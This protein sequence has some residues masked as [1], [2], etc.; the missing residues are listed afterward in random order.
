[1]SYASRL[2]AARGVDPRIVVDDMRFLTVEK[3]G[4]KQSLTPEG[5][6]LIQDTTVARAGWQIYAP[7]EIPGAERFAPPPDGVFR[8]WRDE[9]E[10]FAPE[11]VASANGKPVVDDHPDDVITPDTH[12]GAPGVAL[13]PRRGTGAEDD[14]LIMDLMIYSRDLI[15]AIGDGKR[16]LSLGYDVDYEELEPGKLAQK[17]IRINH[18]ALVDSGR[19]GPRCAIGDHARQEEPHMAKRRN[20]ASAF[21]K[22]RAYL[23]KN[24]AIPAADK[25]ELEKALKEGEAEAGDAEVEPGD[26]PHHLEIHNHMPAAASET[27]DDPID[28]PGSGDLEARVAR[29][30]TAIHELAE[31][32]EAGGVAPTDD[33]PAP[34]EER[35][36]KIEDAVSKMNGEEEITDEEGKAILGQLEL[37][38]P[39]GAE[40]VDVR[41]AKDSRYLADSFRA[42]VALAEIVAPGIRVPA[43]DQKSDP[44]RCF[45]SICDLRR[46]A[47]DLAYSKPDTRGMIEEV[48][49]GRPLDVKKMSC[50]AV[51]SAFNAVGVMK[52]GANN[53]ALRVGDGAGEHRIT[54]ESVGGVQTLTDYQKMLN[55]HYAPQKSA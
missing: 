3:L 2:L 8:V 38:A 50:D 42:T 30:E 1:M 20:G 43:F 6:L 40:A 9:A 5:F 47:L 32:V 35:M 22:L 53:R 27:T 17:N 49:S 14:L 39:P 55:K 44:R 34:W 31:M 26:A 10:V 52:K 29:L 21:D 23:M 13:D 33:E 19:C 11:A 18:I 46:T 45:K 51:R 7:G 28:D 4:P 15:K 36:K 41:R 12:A 48:L 25:E 16:E 54:G 24:T 37:E